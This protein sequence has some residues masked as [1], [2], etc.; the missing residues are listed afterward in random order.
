MEIQINNTIIRNILVYTEQVLNDSVS[1]VQSCSGQIYSKVEVSLLFQV[2]LIA[3]MPSLAADEVTLSFSIR[4]H[5]T[6][7][8]H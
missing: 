3:L 1:I 6:I 2:L 8:L 4:V 5:I 7:N